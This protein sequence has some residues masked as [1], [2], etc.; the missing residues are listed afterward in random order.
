MGYINRNN[1]EL[2]GGGL[3]MGETVFGEEN[4]EEEEDELMEQCDF[5]PKVLGRS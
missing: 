4:D 1:R 2:S 3:Y 5:V